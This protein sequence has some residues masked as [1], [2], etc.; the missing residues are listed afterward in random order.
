[1]GIGAG[2]IIGAV[3]GLIIG[4]LLFSTNSISN[5][6]LFQLAHQTTSASIKQINA[7]TSEY[8]NK[9]VTVSGILGAGQL[10][11]WALEDNQGYIIDVK[12]NNI[13][14]RALYAGSIYTITGIVSTAEDA[15]CPFGSSPLWKSQTVYGGLISANANYTFA[16]NRYTQWLCDNFTNNIPPTISYVDY[17]NATGTGV[18]EDSSPPNP[19]T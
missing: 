7:N 11:G 16:G 15:T 3:I 6:T 9:T 5:N 8:L 2:I 19:Y 10:F 14:N 17:I 12:I 13:G 1:M 4:Y 18:I